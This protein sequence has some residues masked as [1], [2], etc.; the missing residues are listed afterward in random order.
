MKSD[1]FGGDGVADTR[2]QLGF[3]F[4]GANRSRFMTE[5]RRLTAGEVRD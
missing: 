5:F 3:K 1:C 2:C 4:Q